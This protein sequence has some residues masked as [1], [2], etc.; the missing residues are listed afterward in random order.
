M[1]VI[2]ALTRDL[3]KALC[4][5]L[6]SVFV[7]F[8]ILCMRDCHVAETF[9]VWDVENVCLSYL[10][11]LVLMNIYHIRACKDNSQSTY[12]PQSGRVEIPSHDR[13][14]PISSAALTLNSCCA[15]SSKD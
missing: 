3:S 14:W 12:A 10:T 1:D 9:L 7:N 5:S 15:L 4:R 8:S 2:T 11:A 13:I 6:L